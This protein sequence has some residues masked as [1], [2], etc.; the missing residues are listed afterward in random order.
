MSFYE[1][2]CSCRGDGRVALCLS[3]IRDFTNTDIE[4]LVSRMSR[5]I[6]K[7]EGPLGWYQI[8]GSLKAD[9]R[10]TLP[11]KT[12]V[13][14]HPLM[15]GIGVSWLQIYDVFE[16]HTGRGNVLRSGERVDHSIDVIFKCIFL[17]AFLY[18]DNNLTEV[19]SWWFD[20]Q[21][22]IIG[23]DNGLVPHRRQAITGTTLFTYVYRRRQVAMGWYPEVPRFVVMRKWP[24][25]FI[26]PLWRHDVDN[27]ANNVWGWA[28]IDT[29]CA[30]I[31]ECLCPIKWLANWLYLIYGISTHRPLDQDGGNSANNKLENISSMETS[32]VERISVWFCYIP[33]AH[34]AN[35]VW[36]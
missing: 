32:E 13:I 33:V 29:Y 28:G 23:S 30:I 25:I 6:S 19:C 14:S 31:V 3:Q 18:F 20:R 11:V 35:M 2:Y 1:I 9:S 21:K 36:L 10:K 26:P 24:Y 5:N 34:F 15:S 22:V 8:D 27:W 12:P 7:Y 17:N 4:L 16:N